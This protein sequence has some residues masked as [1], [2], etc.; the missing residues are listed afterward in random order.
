MTDLGGE[1]SRQIEELPMPA[2][3]L[4]PRLKIEELKAILSDDC[5][6][7]KSRVQLFAMQELCQDSPITIA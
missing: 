6:I 2:G 4:V 7:N 3:R 5:G 1:R